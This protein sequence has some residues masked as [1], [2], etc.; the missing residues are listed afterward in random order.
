M[1]GKTRWLA[2]LLAACMLVLCG[3]GKELLSPTLQL[4]NVCRG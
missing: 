3:C 1:K 2:L 4:G